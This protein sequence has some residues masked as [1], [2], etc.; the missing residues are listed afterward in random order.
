MLL[1][2]RRIVYLMIKTNYISLCDLKATADDAMTGPLHTP[3]TPTMIL[4]TPKPLVNE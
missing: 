1:L 3:P 4:G 2:Y